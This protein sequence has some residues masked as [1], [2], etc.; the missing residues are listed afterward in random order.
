MISLALSPAAANIGSKVQSEGVLR[1]P[2]P[3]RVVPL[4]V[5]PIRQT[6]RVKARKA[7]SR[8]PLPVERG[9]REYRS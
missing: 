9:F 6:Q 2:A 3:K 1:E 5:A 8:D 4:P 7:K